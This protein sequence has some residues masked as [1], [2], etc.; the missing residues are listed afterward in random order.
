ML[1]RETFVETYGALNRPEDTE[2]HLQTFFTFEQH[3]RELSDRRTAVFMAEAGPEPIGFAQLEPLTPPACVADR[4][5]LAL[6]RLYVRRAWHGQGVARPL[7]VAVLDAARKAGAASLWLSVW[8]HNPRAIA[9][10]RQ[11]GFSCTGTMDF[12]VG[13]EVQNDLVFSLPLTANAAAPEPT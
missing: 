5:A 13:S 9:F 3:E 1:A 6:R 12:V 7:L 10:Y 2:H 11:A 4:T 8:E